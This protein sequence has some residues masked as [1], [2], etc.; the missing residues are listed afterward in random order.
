MYTVG[1]LHP[2]WRAWADEAAA[3]TD[4]V[5][6][7]GSAVDQ[8]DG[9]GLQL[10][11]SL[12]RTLTARNTALRLTEASAVLREGC[13]ALGLSAWLAQLNLTAPEAA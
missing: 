10:L 4:S 8:I 1:E 2:R 13:A 7:D 5:T 9:A 12:C 11:V 3:Q 6:V